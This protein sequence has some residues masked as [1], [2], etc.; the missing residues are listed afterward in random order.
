[1]VWNMGHLFF[2]MSYIPAAAA[3]TKLVAAADC[4]DADP[5][6]LSH[7]WHE[8]SEDHVSLGIRL[9]YCV[10]LGAAVFSTLLIS[11]SHEHK[12]PPL[13]R[14][15]KP[16]RLA[17]R[18]LVSAILCVLPAVPADRLNSLQL[19]AITCSLIFWVLL[20]EIWGVSCRDEAFFGRNR[21]CVYM[22]NCSRRALDEATKEDGKVD[23]REFGRNEKTAVPT[24][25]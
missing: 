1:M 22:A 11:L 8:R 21:K 2:V 13:R 19:V 9:F 10:G 17:N 14:I 5:E 20:F 4:P 12:H 23:V 15:S 25:T 3:L 7:H 16:W 18:A 6:S 24:M